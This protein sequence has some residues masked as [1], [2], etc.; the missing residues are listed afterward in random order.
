MSLADELAKLDDLRRA[1]ALNEAEFAKAK[2]ALLD[3]APAA[4]EPPLGDR[5]ADQLAEV[6]HQNELSQIDRA[7]E[8]ERQQYLVRGRY[9]IAQVPTVGMGVG[10]A[11]VGGVFGLFWTIMAVSITGAAPDFGPFSITKVVFPLFGVGF[12]V[13]AIGYGLYVYSRAQRYQQAFA[14]YQARRARAD[15]K[16]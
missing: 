2:R 1:G 16:R 12:N 9:G 10:T 13:A 11:L 4:S 15:R 6:K 7:R 8:I 3:R 5:L 14:E